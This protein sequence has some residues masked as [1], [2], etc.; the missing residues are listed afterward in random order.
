MQ[1]IMIDTRR[2][3]DRLLNLPEGAREGYLRDTMLRPFRP[4]HEIMGMAPG[5]EISTCLPVGAVRDEEARAMLEQLDKAHAWEQA[6]E[7]VRRGAGRFAAA[8]I[9]VPETVTLGI[10]LG[11]S[12]GLAHCRGYTGVGSIPGYIQIFIAPND[13]NLKRIAACAAHEFHHNV[14]FHNT[15]WNFM[16]E[17]TVARYL[18]VE[19]L[20]E[21]FAESLYGPDA[22]GP[23]VTGISQE[24]LLKARKLLKGN[25]GIRGFG[26]VSP[27]LYG[28]HPMIPPEK[29]TGMPYCGG[30]AAGYHAVQAYLNKTGDCV[31]AATRVDGDEIMKASGYFE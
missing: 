3:Y 18:A 21:S 19:G 23:W 2:Q 10:F 15:S 22:L 14:L 28:D 5:T 4:M 1:I 6:Q 7:A 25:L 16:E 17:V 8:G 26:E 29:A 13:Y 11:D 20:A 12:A 27:W 30:Y 24:E 31:E 9:P